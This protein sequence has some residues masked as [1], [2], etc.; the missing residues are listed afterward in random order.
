MTIEQ[1]QKKYLKKGGEKMPR[2]IKWIIYIA[3]ASFIWR[4]LTALDVNILI[5]KLL[6]S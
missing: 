3:I 6:G 1:L 4:F 2:I 5:Q